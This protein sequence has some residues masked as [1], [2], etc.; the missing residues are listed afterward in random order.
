MNE[1]SLPP[2][3][4]VPA[5]PRNAASAIWSLVLGILGL[6][7][8]G[9]FTG[10]PA[11]ICGHTAQARIRRSGGALTG[12]GLALGGLITGYISIALSVLMIPLLLA[13]A[14]PNFVKARELAQRN[15]CINNLRQLDGAK[16]QWAVDNRRPED[17]VPALGDLERFL[18]SGSAL[19]CPAGGNYVLGA[20]NERPTCSVRGHELEDWKSFYRM[21]EQR[22]P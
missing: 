1:S 2:V 6:V 4:T 17:A 13:I 11:L 7:G 10:I 3:P 9:L 15:A 16:L 20:V 8:F 21:R 12:E 5:A 14:I 18:A 22:V 19:I